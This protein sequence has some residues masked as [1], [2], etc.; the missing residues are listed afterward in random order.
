MLILVL[1]ISL[2]DKVCVACESYSVVCVVDDKV[3]AA[4]LDRYI[5][6]HLTEAVLDSRNYSRTRACTASKSLAVSSLIYSDSSTLENSVAL[7]SLG[8]A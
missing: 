6:A 1:K 4:K 2:I 7:N 8:S 3:A 5:L